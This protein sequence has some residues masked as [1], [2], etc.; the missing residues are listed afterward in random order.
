MAKENRATVSE[1]L[2]I[3]IGLWL[4]LFEA[5]GRK[6]GS[7][8]EVVRSKIGSLISEK[9]EPLGGDWISRFQ[10][11]EQSTISLITDAYQY[12]RRQGIIQSGVDAWSLTID[13]IRYTIYSIFGHKPQPH[14]KGTVRV[15]EWLMNLLDLIFFFLPR[16][17]SAAKVKEFMGYIPTP[18]EAVREERAPAL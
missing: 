7:W 13:L 2:F 5:I 18:S 15:V 9:M 10:I 12:V 17:L 14:M 4:M 6:L 3:I 11:F 16:K 1:A 8:L